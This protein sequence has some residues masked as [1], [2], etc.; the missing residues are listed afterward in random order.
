MNLP[1]IN[2]H[3]INTFTALSL[4][5][6]HTPHTHILPQTHLTLHNPPLG[7]VISS[8][9]VFPLVVTRALI[10]KSVP[11]EELGA[12]FSVLASFEAVIPLASSPLYTCVYNASLH[13]FPGAVF[14]LSA[15][16]FAVAGML[17]VYV[18][19]DCYCYC[20][21]YYYLF[22][23]FFLLIVYILNYIEI[24]YGYYCN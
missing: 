1:L 24:I 2:I 20:Y 18:E 5:P 19:L 7:A 9:G 6:K 12:I 3:I 22:I 21:C 14:M 4:S 17:F 13:V 10:S 11:P 15:V 16:L 8:V 23:F